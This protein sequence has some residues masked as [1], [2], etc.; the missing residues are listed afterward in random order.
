MQVQVFTKEREL[1]KAGKPYSLS[2][3]QRESGYLS[4]LRKLDPILVDGIIRVG[5]RIDK[6]PVCYNVRHPMILPGKHHI[7][8]LIIKRYHRMEGH[9]GISQVLETNRQKFWA[10][11]CPA[12]VKR[13]VGECLTCQRWN[14]RPES[15]IMAPLPDARVTPAQPPFSSVGIDYFGPIPVKVKRSTVKR[16]GCVFTCLGMRAVHIEITY[17][18]STDSFIQAFTRFVSR[19]G[20][21]SQVYS[22]NGTNFKEAEREI[23]HALKNWNQHRILNVL[24]NRSIEWHFN[25]PAASH[26]GGVWERMIRSIR[27]ILRSILGNQLVND[28]TL[29]TLSEVE[30][31]LK[32]RNDL[33]RHE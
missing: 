10:L 9:V 18:L 28:E 8:A 22:D 19:R 16:Y 20:P 11:Q 31:I 2:K 5:G 29:L 14:S 27:K 21:P 23:M 30:K 6:A 17:D 4:P 32:D 33:K 12:A 7:T 26:A 1:I 24:R 15:Q 13:V 25:P 3:V